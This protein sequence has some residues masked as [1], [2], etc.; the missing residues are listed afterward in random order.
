MFALLKWYNNNV[1]RFV[2]FLFRLIRE[3][4][5]LCLHASIK[6]TKRNAF[7]ILLLSFHSY[8]LILFFPSCFGRIL[9]KHNY[10]KLQ[11]RSY[12]PWK[13]ITIIGV[14][15]T[16]SSVNLGTNC[17]QRPKNLILSLKF[18]NIR[19]TNTSAIFPFMDRMKCQF[20]FDRYHF[21]NYI[22]PLYDGLLYLIFMV[23]LNSDAAFYNIF[24][25]LIWDL[26]SLWITSS[27]IQ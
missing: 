16:M 2:F 26:T 11:I 4:I 23:T 19:W 12:Q 13:F 3:Y 22:S 8:H 6:Y 24:L 5:L 17:E 21:A 14:L 25:E 27:D 1:C 9:Y 18:P 20:Y 15:K 7:P 10:C